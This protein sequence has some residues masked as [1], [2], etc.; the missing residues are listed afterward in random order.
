MVKDQIS[1]YEMEKGY[2]TEKLL[3]TL[4][5]LAQTTAF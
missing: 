3:T 2:K 4:I 1:T 5:K